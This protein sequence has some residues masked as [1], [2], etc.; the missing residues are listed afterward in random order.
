[1]EQSST[2]ASFPS[3]I[4]L[5]I[6]SCL[7]FKIKECGDDLHV[8]EEFKF[9]GINAVFLLGSIIATDILYI[10]GYVQ[11]GIILRMAFYTIFFLFFSYISTK[12]LLIKHKRRAKRSK[13]VSQNSMEAEMKDTLERIGFNL[14]AM[15]LIKEHSV[16]HLLFVLEVSKL[17]AQCL[18]HGFIDKKDAGKYLEVR[19][20][21]KRV[22]S[23]VFDT[24]SF[25]RN[26]KH[27]M[28]KYV[29]WEGEYAVNI[30]SYARNNVLSA[31]EELREWRDDLNVD[32]QN[33]NTATSS[34]HTSNLTVST[35]TPP[36]TNRMSINQSEVNMDHFHKKEVDF[37]IRKEAISKMM[38]VVDAG[39]QDV[40]HL[41]ENDSF[42][43]FRC[44][45]EFHAHR[46]NCDAANASNMPW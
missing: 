26:A 20:I 23:E 13:L 17:K 35:A 15:H 6:C 38:A 44:S 33:S 27:I 18:K 29:D 30:S 25:F 3:F 2:W 41:L 42:A 40:W 28:D 5:F 34:S 37:D 21:L 36:T 1:L 39:M 31:F 12:W 24:E 7:A 11:L 4:I 10:F 32:K 43:R 16:H 22:D 46:M 45:K 19:D 14:F 8:Q 9:H